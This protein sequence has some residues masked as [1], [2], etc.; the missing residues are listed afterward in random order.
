M[1]L[2]C[3]SVTLRMN[4]LYLSVKIFSLPAIRFSQIETMFGRKLNK[5]NAEQYHERKLNFTLL[6]AKY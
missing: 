4:E 6:F 3:V 1:V 2:M 5:I